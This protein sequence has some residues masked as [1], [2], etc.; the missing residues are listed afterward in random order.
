MVKESEPHY[1][2]TLVFE[3]LVSLNII[4]S[5]V[6]RRLTRFPRSSVLRHLRDVLNIDVVV[7]GE[8]QILFISTQYRNIVSQL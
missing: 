1:F 6:N 8:H 2:N 7:H 5:A 3:N 4:P